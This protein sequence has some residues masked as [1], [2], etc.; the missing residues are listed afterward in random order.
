MFANFLV[1]SQFC[2]NNSWML[3]KVTWQVTWYQMSSIELIHYSRACSA[4]LFLPLSLFSSFSF[5]FFS[6]PNLKVCV[7]ASGVLI[8]FIYLGE[9]YIFQSKTCM[10]HPHGASDHLE[11]EQPWP[12]QSPSMSIRPWFISITVQACNQLKQSYNPYSQ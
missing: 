2:T 11:G 4:F 9:E 1:C 3:L 10:C 8:L 6:F 5:F 12:C 7:T